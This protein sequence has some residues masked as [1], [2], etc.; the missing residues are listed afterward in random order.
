M[1]RQAEL[2]EPQPLGEADRTARDRQAVSRKRPRERV[3]RGG[4][5]SCTSPQNPTPQ[6]AYGCAEFAAAGGGGGPSTAAKP[7][8]LDFLPPSMLGALLRDTAASSVP[9]QQPPNSR[10]D[11]STEDALQPAKVARLTGESGDESRPQAVSQPN[12]C[13][14]PTLASAPTA[15]VDAQDE[16]SGSADSVVGGGAAAADR[17]EELDSDAVSKVTKLFSEWE[18]PCFRGNP[19]MRSRLQANDCNSSRGK[20]AVCSVRGALPTAVPGAELSPGGCPSPAAI[21]IAC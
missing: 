4:A 18:N 17:A 21:L 15:S 20:L 7:F 16:L 11:T 13:P 12:D 19:A 10:G 8:Q 5:H 2:S 9:V 14:Q 1:P 3:S 6:M